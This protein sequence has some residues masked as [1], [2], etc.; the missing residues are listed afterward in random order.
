MHSKGFIKYTGNA[1]HLRRQIDILTTQGVSEQNILIEKDIK[2]VIDTLR[3]G[4]RLV[5]S[6]L[7]ETGQSILGLLRVLL[8]IMDRGAELV[9]PDAPW[10]HRPGK[11][12]DPVEWLRG[13]EQFGSKTASEKTKKALNDARATG[14]K[15]GR[16]QGTSREKNERCRMAAELYLHSQ[17]SVR[18]ICR[19]VGLDVGSL[20][21]YLKSN[22]LE[23]GGRKKGR[24]EKSPNPVQ[25]A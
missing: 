13:L 23:N 24:K 8:K 5:V 6:S 14:K 10:L 18:T 16:P 1:A 19:S 12:C 17:M 9:A 3:P 20:Y 25:S 21:A 7:S 22:G 2:G 15:L 11:S 4:D